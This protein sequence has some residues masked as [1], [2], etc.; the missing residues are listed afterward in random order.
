MLFYES[1]LIFIELKSGKK[2]RWLRRGRSQLSNTIKLFKENYDINE[3]VV[4][5]YVCNN[6]RPFGHS[7]NAIHIQK[8]KEETQVILYPSRK[9]IIR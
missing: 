5:A 3:Y 8:F 4:E 9:I 2:T 6:H 7:G 1:N